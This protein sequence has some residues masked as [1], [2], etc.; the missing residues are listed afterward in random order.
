MAQT[1]IMSA[2]RQIAAERKIDIED[3]I[4]AIKQGIKLSYREKYQF[5][6]KDSLDV[7]IDAEKGYI[8]VLLSK[9]VVKTVSEPNTEIS[10]VDAKKINSKAKVGS[11]VKV[12]ITLQ[13]DFGRIA[14][15][16]ARQVILQKLREAEKEAVIRQ[17]TGLEGT[18]ISVTVQRILPEGDV[19][20]EVN[21]AKALMPKNDRIPNEFYK[22]G[23]HIKVLLKKIDEDLKG[24]YMLV[25][26]SDPDFLKELFR[27]EVPEIE[28]GSVEI[29][30]IAREAGARSKVA[31][32]SNAAG[33]DPIGSCVGQKGVRINAISN[34][35]KS[36]DHEEKVDIILWD[37]NIET[38]L[39]NA[40][41][42]ADSIKV[43]IKD[44]KNRVATIVVPDDQLSLA[45][46]KD[47]QNARLAN[48]LT[49]WTIDIKGENDGKA[50][51][52]EAKEAP[53]E[54][55]TEEQPAEAQ[56]EAARQPEI[57]DSE[58]TT[59]SAEPEVTSPEVV[60]KKPKTKK[61][62]DKSEAATPEIK[63]NK[64]GV[65]EV[66]DKKGEVATSQGD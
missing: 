9:K 62:K 64:E 58:P 46:G 65:E 32:K 40:I 2:I 4:E 15:Q 44:K 35:L 42:P 16:A 54:A 63:V 55:K 66:A 34:E 45:I 7:E 53:V 28:S 52:V 29:V 43:E 11:E 26:R 21:K 50:K 30:S 22:I 12:D 56:P 47:G 60:E 31:V 48:K 33:V 13:G 23:G 57:S 37:D 49:G 6:N 41:R 61:K 20:C 14:A 39:M 1:D 17:F 8:A 10:L 27:L 3:I 19:L 18:I 36:G 5:D 38:F 59:V 25:S 24:K 51:P